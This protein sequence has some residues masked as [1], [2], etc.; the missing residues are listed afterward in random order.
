[1]AMQF[2]RPDLGEGLVLVIPPLAGP[3]RSIKLMLHG[4]DPQ[5]GY[6]LHWQIANRKTKTTG[7]ELMK[8]L[9]AAVP[10]GDGGERIV[11]RKL[12]D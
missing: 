12:R 4:L 9:E 7:A 8:G 11:Y 10:P 5:A 6:E 1:M 3:E 2:H